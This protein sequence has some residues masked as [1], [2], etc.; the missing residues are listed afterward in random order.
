MHFILDFTAMYIIII[1]II[2][3]TRETGSLR[4]QRIKRVYIRIKYHT[5]NI[6]LQFI[7]AVHV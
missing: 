4:R 2:V 1:V 3:R 5:Y 7:R 6:V